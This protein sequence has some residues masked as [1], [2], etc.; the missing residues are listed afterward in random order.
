MYTGYRIRKLWESY[1]FQGWIFFVL[2]MTRTKTIYRNSGSQKNAD[3][4]MIRWMKI[5]INE[6]KDL[7]KL[8]AIVRYGTGY[9]NIDVEA[10][11]ITDKLFW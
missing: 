8:K 10:C 3:G 9:Y 4:L 11:S 1:L 6:I 7:L 2:S 5:D